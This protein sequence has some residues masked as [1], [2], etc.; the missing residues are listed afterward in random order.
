M[1]A[2]HQ[3][4]VSSG[5]PRSAVGTTE[6]HVELE[7]QV[8]RFL[9]KEDAMIFG[10]GFG[11]NSTGVPALIGKGGLIISDSMNHSSIAIGARSSGAVIKV[12]KH[13]DMKHLE[14]VIR[15]AIIDGQPLTHR[16]WTKILIMVEGIYSMEGE[17]CHL[18]EVI[19]IKKKYNCY[20]YVDEGNKQH[21]S[22][23]VCERIVHS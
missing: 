21:R 1:N 9:S 13:N 16:P 10:M 19:A 20:L 17:M 8:A 11:T 4:G 23:S 15:R 22:P 3:Y 7:K 5:S 12:F 6:L 18:P 2:L 14:A